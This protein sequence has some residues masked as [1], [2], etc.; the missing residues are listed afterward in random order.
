ME[1][2]DE[3]FQRAKKYREE[4]EEYRL[5]NKQKKEIEERMDKVKERVAVMLHADKLNE[6]IVE[7]SNGEKWKATYQ[8]TSRSVT[9]LKVLMEVVGP[10]KY[11]EIVSQKESTFLT[12][13]KDGKKKTENSLL[14]AKPV[15]DEINKPLIPTGTVLS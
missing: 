7:L 6:S 10:R 9:D 13:R 2:N 4:Y 11:D 1:H 5:L 8:T 15:E 3:K 14:T 12:I